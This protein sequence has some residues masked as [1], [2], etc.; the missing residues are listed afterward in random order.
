MKKEKNVQKMKRKMTALVLVVA[1]VI[2][3]TNLNIMSDSI[4]ATQENGVENSKGKEEAVVVRELEDE[5]TEN[6]NTY[7][8]SDGSKKTDIYTE[9]IRYKENG[10][11]VE[12]DSALT[13][14]NRMD[15]KKLNKILEDTTADNY[16]MVNAKGDSKQYFPKSLDENNGIVM[17]YKKYVLGFMPMLSKNSRIVPE[18]G[19]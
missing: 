7:L 12:Y 18:S 5:R 9:N 13:A 3:G 4:Y 17:N 1:L 10:A 2:T 11:L 6:S 14:L 8:M 16:I 15:K 19:M